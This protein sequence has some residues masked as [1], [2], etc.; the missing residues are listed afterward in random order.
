VAFQNLP[1]VV[2]RLALFMYRQN[3]QMTVLEEAGLDTSLNVDLKSCKSDLSGAIGQLTLFQTKLPEMDVE[4]LSQVSFR[5]CF[6]LGWFLYMEHLCTKIQYGFHGSLNMLHNWCG[7]P[8]C[9]SSSAKI[10]LHAMI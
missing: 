4:Q 1:P 3:D 7:T 10:H 5:T 2:Y 9:S 6:L 8:C